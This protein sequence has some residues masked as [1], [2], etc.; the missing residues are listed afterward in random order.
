MLTEQPDIEMGVADAAISIPDTEWS[1]ILLRRST[2][3]VPRG[4]FRGPGQR[5]CGMD[6]V[7]TTV[8]IP[9]PLRP[10]NFP[11]RLP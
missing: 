4:S 1:T 3:S 5:D 9:D 7:D 10:P 11:R 8:F 6:V 2:L